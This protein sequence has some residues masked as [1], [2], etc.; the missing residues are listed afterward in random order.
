MPGNRAES[1][2]IKRSEA[3]LLIIDIQEKLSNTMQREPFNWF[4]RNVSI[5]IESA[6]V[7]NIPIFLTE[8]YPKG[9][10]PT[11]EEIK[12][13]L[14]KEIKPIHKI[15]FSCALVPEVVQALKNSGRSQIIACGMET[16]I[17]VYQTVRDLLINGY[18]VFV[19]KDGVISRITYNLDVGINLMERAGAITSSTEAIVFDLLEC[20]GTPEF[21]KIA[22]LIK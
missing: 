12:Q 20:A 22:P 5:L 2:R 18:Q 16:H 9:L 14:P 10:G 6:K 13:L 15:E 7:L 17:C 11:L 3:A 8:Q 19:P 1:M 21:K 4:L